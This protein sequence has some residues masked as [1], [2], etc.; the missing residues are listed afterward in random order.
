V[1][2]GKLAAL[3]HN[4][5]N[6]IPQRL[7]RNTQVPANLSPDYKKA[8]QAYRAAA[9]ERERLACLKDMLRTI[10][11]HKG[12]EHLQADLKSRIK[13]LSDELSG[14]KK[15]G[16]RVGPVHLVRPEGAAQ[17]AL[18]GPA[19][20]GKSSLHVALT[21]S[22][23]AIG[24]YPLTTHEP[25]AGMCPFE[26]IYL[27]L[28]DLPPL[29]PDFVPGWLATALQPADAAILVIDLTDP[30]GPEQIEFVL[31]TL[32]AKRIS[33][34]ESWEAG[35]V[36]E[37]PSAG[38]ESFDPF[39][40]NLPT[41][42]VGNKADLG[43]GD[44]DLS[45]LKELAGLKYQ[46]LAVSATS[47]AGMGAIAPFLFE[48]LKIVRVYTKTPGKP[49]EMKK[50]FTLRAGATVSDVA[51]LVHKEM[52]DS[53]RYARAWGTGVFDGQQVGPEHAV[54]DG[55]VLELHMR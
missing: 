32:D 41:L 25:M 15:G 48:A 49:A 38:E 51:R 23:A 53:L 6:G 43:N 1:L 46:S 7:C 11:K 35:D 12:T 50:P 28:V 39:R 55:D 14:P 37:C 47:G 10:P 33:L 17:I 27:Q 2:S 8:E 13:S 22:R 9:D 21:S 19:N 4:R 29:S 31:A 16:T 30:D 42:M 36:G 54:T 34:V 26:D 52:A 18:I 40:I 5:C 45:A 44:E 20:S 3:M 24:P